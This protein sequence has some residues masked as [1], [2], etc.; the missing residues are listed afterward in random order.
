MADE[1]DDFEGRLKAFSE[2]L[3]GLSESRLEL[4]KSADGL[5]GKILTGHLIAEE[6]LTICLEIKCANPERLEDARLGFS[7]KVNLV[8]A[9]E[10]FPMITDHVWPLV[11]KLNSLRNHLVHDLDQGKVEKL[12]SE[13]ISLVNQTQNRSK[14]IAKKLGV[15]EP[16]LIDKDS[17]D[18]LFQAL[19][20]TLGALDMLALWT[21]HLDALIAQQKND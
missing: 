9:F 18:A 10:V 19:H 2:S 16:I 7:Q 13:F 3:K 17:D 20:Y 15:E 4:L 12:S 11:F 6:L 21:N 1:D 8:R 14:K 5:V